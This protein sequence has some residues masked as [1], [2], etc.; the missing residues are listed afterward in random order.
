MTIYSRWTSARWFLRRPR[1]RWAGALAGLVAWLV[2]AATA[3]VA[4]PVGTV[5]EFPVP[6]ANS[7]PVGITSGP[8]GNM[9]F[10]EIQGNKIGRI[11]STG[12]ITESG[13]GISPNS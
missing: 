2:F 4:A 5:A 1:P 8:D 13:A 12:S 7:A 6:T 10:T 11:T 3:A 9:W